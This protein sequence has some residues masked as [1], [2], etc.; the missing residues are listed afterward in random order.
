MGYRIEDSS[1]DIVVEVEA[2]DASHALVEMARGIAA[3]QTGGSDVEPRGERG[4]DVTGRDPAALLVAFANEVIFA[5]DADGFLTAG[6]ELAYEQNERHRVHGALRGEPFDGDRHDR[7]VEVKAATFHD[8]RFER[9]DDGW[10]LRL[11]L[12]L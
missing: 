6:G 9:V 4:V 3:V 8:L 10:R 1:G 7:G 2:D 5:F 11:L 12:D